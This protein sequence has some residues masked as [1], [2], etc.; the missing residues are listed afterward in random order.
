MD[1]YKEELIK[2]LK[3]TEGHLMAEWTQDTT[4]L[5]ELNA[6]A[7]ESLER[8]NPEGH[9]AALFIYHQL[10]FEILRLL[11]I[12]ANFLIKLCLYPT[13][14]SPKKYFTDSKFSELI[15]GLKYSI[16]FKG[17]A[18]ILS[19][20]DIIN[21]LRNEFGHRINSYSDIEKKLVNIKAI[22]EGIFQTWLICLKDLTSL[23]DQA[24]KRQEIIKLLKD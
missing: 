17:K 16:N 23:I 1:S 9:I 24:K 4:P 6:I 10:T 20:A 14:F 2:Y 3:N 7:E 19:Q 13:K 18:T 11:L 21:K 8:K 15:S 12:R 5:S 22:H